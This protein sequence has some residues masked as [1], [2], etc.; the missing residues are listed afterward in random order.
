MKTTDNV[1]ETLGAKQT[2]DAQIT[3]KKVLESLIFCSKIFLFW[4]VL[5]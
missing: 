3:V 2:I 1:N 5:M 4:V